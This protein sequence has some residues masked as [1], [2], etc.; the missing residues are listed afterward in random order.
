MKKPILCGAT[1]ALSVATLAMGVQDASAARV[2]RPVPA[3]PAAPS[4]LDEWA[5]INMTPANVA[6]GHAGAGVTVAVLDGRADCTHPDLAGRCTNTLV[7]GGRYRTYDQH[8]THTSGIV[9]GTHYGVAPSAKIL[10]YAVFDNRGYAAVD[11]NLIN[12]WYDAA[13]KGAS[14]ASMSF[15]CT[16]TAL[17]FEAAEVQAMA[18]PALKL[19]FVKSAGNDGVAVANEQ[20]AITQA[21]AQAAIDKLLLVGSIELNGTLASYS[22]RP[23]NGCL[24]YTG[25]TDCSDP[26]LQWKNHFLVA[27]GSNIYSTLPKGKFGYMSGTS[28]AAPVV[29]GV[30]ALIESKWPTLKATPEAVASIILTSATDIGAPGVDATY[31]WGLLNVGAALAPSGALTITS[32]SGQAS[33]VTP[34]S[35][36]VSSSMSGLAK[37]LASTTAYDRFGRDYSLAE[38]GMLRIRPAQ[39]AVHQ[40]LGRS[41]SGMGSQQ[42]WAGSF[43][44]DKYQARGFA[45]FASAAEPAYGIA[46]Q[47]RSLR[48]GVDMPFKGGV[49]QLRLTGASNSRLDFAYDPSLR[50]L[51]FFSSTDLLTSSLFMHTLLNVSSN[52]RLSIYG[53]TSSTGNMTPT[54][55]GEPFYLR[56]DDNHSSAAFALRG[57][58]ADSKQNGVGMGY[59]MQPD[60][61]TVIGFNASML[62][63]KGGYYN[64][65]SDL[66]MFE[67]PTRVANLGVAASRSMGSWEVSAS[68]EVT[69]LSAAHA[70]DYLHLTSSNLASGEVR[71]RKSG[72]AFGG[73]GKRVNDSLALAFVV[74]PRAVSGSLKLGYMTRTLDGLGRQAAD[75]RLA[76]SDLGAEPM[77]VEA[78]YRLSDG[79]AWSFDL[80]GGLNMEKSYYGGAGELLASAKFAF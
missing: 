46:T 64:L 48:M 28:M 78:A 21:Q 52:S 12:F 36:V 74:P 10:N 29:S 43:F 80:T 55:A 30:A 38:S 1:L 4:N 9:G 16:G 41:L 71:V 17:C 15:G 67:K 39:S 68:S 77:K 63:Q 72:I 59:W 7:P 53:T 60:S 44:A 20:I 70:A 69:H 66:D 65:A 27:P 34:G 45:S 25:A 37:K 50:P 8:G 79:K 33:L 51:S 22:N 57:T 58:R 13:S 14:I 76:L 3:P 24:Q 47:D 40:L 5:L 42:D 2:R 26:D 62:S 32:T 18:D 35:L 31:G 23:G 11:N 61:K 73:Y 75:G 19:L 6:D 49:A 56:N 54:L